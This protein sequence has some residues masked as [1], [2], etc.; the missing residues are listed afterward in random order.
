MV[1]F[2]LVYFI[3]EENVFR[4]VGLMLSFFFNCSDCSESIFLE[5]FVKI[6]NRGKL[7]DVNRRVV[8]YFME[9]GSG[10]EGFFFFC[11]IMNMFCMVKVVYYK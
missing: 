4:R 1:F 11:G 10:Y 3:F 5:I 6:I 7:F 2:C 9:I 8:Y